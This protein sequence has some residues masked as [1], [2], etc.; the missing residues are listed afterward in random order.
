MSQTVKSNPNRT[1]NEAALAQFEKHL[2]H[3]VSAGSAQAIERQHKKNKLTIPE[4]LD[5]LFDS[6]APRFE[7]GAFAAMGMYAEEGDIKSATVRTVIG[8]VSGHDCIVIANDSMVKSGTWF[9]MTI[10][11]MLRA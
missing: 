9:P 3:Y 1:A 10:K 6:G 8:R 11:K 4:R 5:I 7:V 2:E